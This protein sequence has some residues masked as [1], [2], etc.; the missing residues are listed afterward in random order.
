MC[1]EGGDHVSRDAETH[2]ESVKGGGGRDGSKNRKEREGGVES[3]Q[4]HQG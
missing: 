1:P 3:L 4:R 2:S